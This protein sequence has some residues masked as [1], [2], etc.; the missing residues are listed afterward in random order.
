MA[1]INSTEI[2]LSNVS[3]SN[4]F[5]NVYSGLPGTSTNVIYDIGKDGLTISLSGW[6]TSE[7]EYSGVAAEFMKSGEQSL[8][9]TEGWEYKVFCTGIQRNLTTMVN[10]IAWTATVQTEDPYVYSLDETYRTKTITTNNQTWTADDD[11]NPIQ[12]LQT[13]TTVPDVEITGS[14][15]D[16]LSDMVYQTYYVGTN[17]YHYGDIYWR[18]IYSQTFEAKAGRY[19]NLNYVAGWLR[20]YGGSHNTIYL[21]VRVSINGAA[22]TTVA[23]FSQYDS[24]I[25]PPYYFHEDTIDISAPEGESIEI[26]FYIRSSTSYVG[27]VRYIEFK[28]D[29]YRANACEGAVL[30]N[31]ADTTTVL[32]MCNRLPL[33]AT[34]LLNTDGTGTAEWIG[35]FATNAYIEEAFLYTGLSY[36]TG[37]ITVGADGYIIYDFDVKYPVVGIPTFT[38]LLDNFTG[39][40]RVQ[41]AEDLAGA[42][43]IFYDIDDTLVD[44]TLTEYDLDNSVSL[45]LAGA[46]RFYVK[47]MAETG[48][49]IDISS[50]TMNANINPSAASFPEIAGSGATNSFRCDQYATSEM[51]CEISL[52]YSE[53]KYG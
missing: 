33:D 39:T 22:E 11:S 52:I 44:G 41:I 4:K 14:T 13:T 48:E 3:I 16:T 8:V 42:P 18:L 30:Y 45:Q 21:D 50:F 24:D 37:T 34:L 53:R 20:A 12:N 28:L 25:S 26:R 10:Y 27:S 1:S 43:D 29:E 19:Y 51:D 7:S 46:T 17:T 40:P 47:I 5:R 15:G 36:S 31:T 49:A 9:V 35:H 38:A 6:V 2:N 23:S 32:D